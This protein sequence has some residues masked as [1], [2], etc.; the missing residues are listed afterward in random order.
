MAK[1][2][3]GTGTAAEIVH[4]QTGRPKAGIVLV[5]DIMGLRPLFEEHCARISKEWKV[6]VCAPELFPG[7]EK[8]NLDQRMKKAKSLSDEDKVGDILAAAQRTGCDTVHVIGFC[9]GGMYALKAA[10][11]ERFTK[12]VSFYG[13]VR[14][15][16]Q[17]KGKGQAEPLELLADR[18]AAHVMEIVGTKDA[19]VPVED[20]KELEAIGATVVVYKGAEH[21]FIHDADRPAHRPKD[22]KD[23]WTRAKKFLGL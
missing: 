19:Y 23:A 10:A 13:M 21:G 17:W 20:A 5:P 18:G 22:A 1:I 2:E 14:V 4:P 6:S 7:M 12:A 11:N 8:L 9:M 3:L 16:K 15:P